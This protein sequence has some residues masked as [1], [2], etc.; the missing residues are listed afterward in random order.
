MKINCTS[1]WP[2]KISDRHL[3]KTSSFVYLGSTVSVMEELTK[4]SKSESTLKHDW[5]LTCRRKYGIHVSSP[6]KQNSESSIS[7]WKDKCPVVWFRN[8]E[9]HKAINQQIANICQQM[10]EKNLEVIL[11]RQSNKWKS[12]E[13]SK[14]RSHSNRNQAKKMEMDWLNVKATSRQCYKA[15]SEMKSPR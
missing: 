5:L 12:L 11:D 6:A 7:M 1:S 10:F 13:A 9:K 3:E 2:I 14:S 15:S 4:T 8:M